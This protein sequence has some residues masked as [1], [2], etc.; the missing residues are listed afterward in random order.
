MSLLDPFLGVPSRSS[1]PSTPS[2][3]DCAKT[4]AYPII[5]WESRSG[6]S[7]HSN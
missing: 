2:G 5:D 7:P 6:A 3:R 4:D 1:T